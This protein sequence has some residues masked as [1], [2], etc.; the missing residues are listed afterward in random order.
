MELG[1]NDTYTR[2]YWAQLTKS[3]HEHCID[4]VYRKSK[5]P[6]GQKLNPKYMENYTN[7]LTMQWT[8][9]AKYYKW[10]DMVAEQMGLPIPQHPEPSADEGGDDAGDD[11]EE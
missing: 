11:D 6:A 9:E 10:T 8:D 7:C 5:T 1:M 3:I 2:S 4:R